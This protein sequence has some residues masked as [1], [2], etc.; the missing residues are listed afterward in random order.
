VNSVFLLRPVIHEFVP[1][2]VGDVGA[3]HVRI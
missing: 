3:D 1:E 2:E